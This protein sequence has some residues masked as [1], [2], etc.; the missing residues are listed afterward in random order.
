M[1]EDVRIS[2]MNLRQWIRKQTI[3]NLLKQL[4]GFLRK[5]ILFSSCGILGAASMTLYAAYKSACTV[6][7]VSHA[8]LRDGKHIAYVERLQ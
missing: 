8:V 5:I 3:L 1:I 7:V 4:V 2:S 6:P